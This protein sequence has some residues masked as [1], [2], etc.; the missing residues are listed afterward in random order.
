MRELEDEQPRVELNL[1]AGRWQ[2]LALADGD[3]GGRA[4]VSERRIVAACGERGSKHVC[5]G[6]GS[7][8]ERLKAHRRATGVRRKQLKQFS[9]L[10]DLCG[11]GERAKRIH[12]SAAGR[13]DE[14]VSRGR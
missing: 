2:L 8:L 7:A 14:D 3:D 4:A 1:M 12:V 6:E 5:F 11:E 9:E 10:R 13:E